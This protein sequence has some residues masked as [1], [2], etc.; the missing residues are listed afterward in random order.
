MRSLLDWSSRLSLALLCLLIAVS[1]NPASAATPADEMGKLAYIQDGDVWA[2]NLPDGEPRRLTEDGSHTTPR[3]SPSAH[4]L[5]SRQGQQLWLTGDPPAQ[6]WAINSGADVGAFSWSPTEDRLAYVA[7]GELRLINAGAAGGADPTA[8]PVSIPVAGQVYRLAWSPDGQWLAYDAT[9]ITAAGEP[10]Q[11]T[12]G[13]WRVRSNG[14]GVTSVYSIGPEADNGL[15]L[16]DWSPDG[17]SVLFWPDPY[18]SASILADGVPLHAVPAEGGEPREIAPAMLLHPSFLAATLH[19]DRLALVVGAGRETW[20]NK[21]LLVVD[22]DTDAQHIITSP[23]TAVTQPRFSPDG[24]RLAYVSA[25]DAGPVGGGEAA[26]VNAAQ[27]HIWVV[28]VNG[29]GPRQLTNE[30]PFRD[31]RPL[32]SAD[33]TQILFAR[34][35]LEGRATIW[36]APAEGGPARPVVDELTPA[37]DWFGYYGYIDWGSLFDWWRGSPDQQALARAAAV[38]GWPTYSDA[39]YGISLQYP[40]GWKSRADYGGVR[41]EGPDGF[42]SLNASSGQGKTLDAVTELEAHQQLQPY[43]SNPEITAVEV[44]GRPARLI[45]PSSDQSPEMQGQA[46]LV[47][48]Y[49]QPITLEGAHYRFLILYADQKHIQDISSTLHWLT[50]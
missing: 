47:V 44:Q 36:L 37:P 33:G 21:R 2:R 6:H 3:W 42:F 45:L 28:Q 22:L 9:Q 31:E 14:S 25:P 12:A 5:A 7:A 49:P 40:D 1:L 35:D 30:A 20:T 10:P 50:P 13:L 38:A 39:A 11:R 17:K 41:Y 34:I 15:V 24:E 16:A 26:K 4:W 23:E 29:S 19:G 8:S 43:G 27:R 48:E 32:W 18:F 46:A